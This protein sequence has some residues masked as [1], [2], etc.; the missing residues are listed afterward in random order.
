M[1]ELKTNVT[2]DELKNI[3]TPTVIE[4]MRTIKAI[5]TR[6]KDPDIVKLEYIHVYDTLGKEFSDFSDKHTTIFT[7]VIRGENLNTIASVLYYKDKVERGLI[8]EEQLSELLA[9]RYLPSHLKEE[10]DAK[11]KEMKSRGEI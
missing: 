6:M 2:H 5:Q 7:K 8:T 1:S 9:K 11:I 10:S 3:T 4:I